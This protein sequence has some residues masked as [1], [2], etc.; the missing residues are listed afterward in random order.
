MREVFHLLLDNKKERRLKQILPSN[1]VGLEFFN[2][3]EVNF[4]ADTDAT[5]E[6]VVDA[7]TKLKVVKKDDI[8]TQINKYEKSNLSKSVDR[9]KE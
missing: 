1:L 8:E 2:N 9:I 7:V 4:D 6:L 3:D 5:T